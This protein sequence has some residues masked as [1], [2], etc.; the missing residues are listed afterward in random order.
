MRKFWILFLATGFMTCAGCAKPVHKDWAASGG[1][2]ADATVEVG[3]TY[4]PPSEKPQTNE[5]QGLEEALKRC[6]SWGYTN[7]EPFGLYKEQCQ[8]W[9]MTIFGPGACI[10]M[11]VTRQYQC[12]GQG[13][14]PESVNTNHK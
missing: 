12:L 2:R 10:N 5:T 11:L 9:A 14:A 6:K 13:N 4:H 3:F 1:S 8:Q 7:A